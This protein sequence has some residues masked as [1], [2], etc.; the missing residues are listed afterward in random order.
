MQSCIF[1]MKQNK[2]QT[3]IFKGPCCTPHLF[4]SFHTKTRGCVSGALILSL[5]F[6]LLKV[7]VLAV[8]GLSA[9]LESDERDAEANPAL[10]T[11]Y[12]RAFDLPHFTPKQRHS[13]LFSR[14]RLNVST[15]ALL[16]RYSS[17]D[18]I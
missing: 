2:G 14:L 18:T 11:F 8:A 7:R 5:G 3:E 13:D 4:F 15:A 16:L 10:V 17:K 9:S 1:C 12:Q 6:H